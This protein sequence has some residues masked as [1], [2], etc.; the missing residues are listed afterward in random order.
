MDVFV[1]VVVVVSGIFIILYDMWWIDLVIMIGIVVY[2][3]YLFFV[4]IGG[5]ICILM[6]GSLLDIDSKFVLSMMCG[7]E[8]VD[9][10]YYVYFW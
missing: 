6:F 2:I 8:G 9:D 10:V 3:F 5:L 4:E 7:V 1:F